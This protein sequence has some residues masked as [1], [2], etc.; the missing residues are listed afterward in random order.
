MLTKVVDAGPNDVPT[1]PSSMPPPPS[2]PISPHI[3][4]V[5]FESSFLCF[6]ITTVFIKFLSAFFLGSIYVIYH[7]PTHTT[8]ASTCSQGG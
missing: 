6:Q 5:F 8:A 3:G 2:L 7:T 1:P 4:N